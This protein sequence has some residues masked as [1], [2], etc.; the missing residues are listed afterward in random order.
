M[1]DIDTSQY[2]A[3]LLEEH[4]RLLQAV[5]FL[6]RENPGS[7]ADE[8]GDIV[9]SGDDNLG[10]TATATYERELDEG[11]EEGAQQTLIAIDDALRKIEDGTLRHLRGVRE[12]DRRRPAGGDPVGAPLHR[13]PAQGGRLSA[14]AERYS[15]RLVDR[16]ARTG[17]G[18][19]ALAAARVRGSG[20][21]SALV[22]VA[23][24]AADQV[25]K[26]VVTVDV[27]LDESVHVLGPLSIHHVQNSG[28]AFGLFSGATAV[29]VVVTAVAVVWML[30]FFA[31]SG[32]RHPVLPAA[33][34]LVIGG[35]V[36]N[37]FDRVRLGHVTDFIDVNWWPGSSTSP[38]ASS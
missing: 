36:S 7:I 6:E 23:A 21:G 38:T 33:F 15:R 9:T 16:R 3:R 14:G 17:V 29:V 31:R 37:L 24:V 32:A 19:G 13:R 18:R 20:P 12:A 10:D 25:T 28:I 11:L 34:G 8:L 35:S 2:R 30:V 26:H 5:D 4:E 1:T 27:A 22:A